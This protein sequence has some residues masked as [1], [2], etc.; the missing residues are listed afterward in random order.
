MAV[1]PAGPVAARG[2][3][4]LVTGTVARGGSSSA[5]AHCS[6]LNVCSSTGTGTGGQ[7]VHAGGGDSS[8]L[9]H[10]AGEGEDEETIVVATHADTGG[11]VE[12]IAFQTVTRMGCRTSLL[13][14]PA[15]LG[16]VT[17]AEDEENF[18]HCST[19]GIE[20]RP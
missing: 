5:H 13:S 4:C 2:I 7:S 3:L 16:W 8:W 20:T 14:I 10:D 19:A 11:S 12:P 17:F 15:G 1:L 18:E 9:R 6:Q